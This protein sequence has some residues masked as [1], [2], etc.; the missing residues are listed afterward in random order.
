MEKINNHTEQALS[1]LI[2]AYK[3]KPEFN[4]FM[5]I[6][7]SDIQDIEN[8]LEA[9]YTIFDIDNSV[10][11]QLDNIGIF[12]GQPRNA[13]SDEEY[14]TFLKAKIAINIGS[15][16]ID[17]ILI[18]WSTIIPNGNIELVENFPAEIELHTDAIL[19]PEQWDFIKKFDS[20]LVGGVRLGNIVNYDETN[21]FAF[22]GEL[23]KDAIDGF[24]AGPSDGIVGYTN[25]TMTSNN[26]SFYVELLK[27]TGLSNGDEYL[28]RSGG[29]TRPEI[30]LR[31]TGND[32]S[33]TYYDSNF[34]ST[35]VSSS[36]TTTEKFVKIFVNATT[37][38][39]D[40][41][42]DLWID[43]LKVDTITTTTLPE[44]VFELA[45]S[46]AN[47]HIG[48]WGDSASESGTNSAMSNLTFYSQSKSD[49][50]I[51]NILSTYNINDSDIVFNE[52]FDYS[53]KG[54]IYYGT[55]QY[56]EIQEAEYIDN[57]NTG[58][59]GDIN[60]ANV[61]GKLATII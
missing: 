31:T 43:G 35:T 49:N 45:K 37:S 4:K 28:Y 8:A 20:I 17:D 52:P 1:R 32:F 16:T 50:D 27:R 53:T 30:F 6:L 15:G 13:A 21:A 41:I 26:F 23:V 48:K 59:F 54:S 57:P 18:A 22:A 61:G 51:E 46:S 44:Y 3:D 39:T 9:F 19:T 58:G 56:I 24:D 11:K 40:L 25:P 29:E 10:G 2:T 60:D 55:E 5:A 12:I 36:I 47:A 14:R 38:G 42:L 33:F 34:V 7:V